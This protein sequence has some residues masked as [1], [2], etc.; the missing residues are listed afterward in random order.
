MSRTAKCMYVPVAFAVELWKIAEQKAFLKSVVVCGTRSACPLCSEKISAY[1]REELQEGLSRVCAKGWQVVM[2]TYTLKHDRFMSAGESLGKLIKAVRR[3]KSGRRWKEIK[4]RYRIEGS[5]TA[6]ENTFSFLNGHHPHKHV[7]EILAR[8]LTESELRELRDEIAKLY[9]GELKRFGADAD[10][11]IAVDVRRGND[12]A[13]EYISKFGYEPKAKS[14]GVVYE[15]ANYSGKTKGADFGHY[16]MMQL[17]DLAGQDNNDAGK[18]FLDYVEAFRGRAMLQWS[19]GLRAKL[20]M[21][22]KG[23][24]D[25]EKAE[26]SDEEKSRCFALSNT[27]TERGWRK[28]R[29]RLADFV[30]GSLGKDFHAYKEYLDAKGI[31]IENPAFEVVDNG[32]GE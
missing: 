18:A 14:F 7:L 3:V 22:P 12:Y 5:I 24:S 11:E 19:A 2:V 27:K 32:F 15:M 29:E 6:L 26:M 10:F 1:D 20:G 30:V 25:K 4:S 9:L 13:A 8:I 23:K 21:P 17:V 16:T 28:A 31:E